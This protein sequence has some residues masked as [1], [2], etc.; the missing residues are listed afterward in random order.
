MCESSLIVQSTLN[1]RNSSP[2]KCCTENAAVFT[3]PIS[4]H[5]KKKDIGELNLAPY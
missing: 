4:P 1:Q 2:K 5:I 3:F